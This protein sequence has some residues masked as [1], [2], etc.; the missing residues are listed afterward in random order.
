MPN[1]RCSHCISFGVSCTHVEVTKNLGSAKSY[2]E[3][4]EQRMAK[5]EKLFGKHLPGLDLNHEVDRTTLDEGES[6]DDELM[7]NDDD[8]AEARL[9]SKFQKLRLRPDEN[10]FY[11]KSSSV[12]LVKTTLDVK[13][14][15]NVKNNIHP[16]VWDFKR[17]EFWE[18]R[19]WHVR[20]PEPRRPLFKFPA[21][22]LMEQLVN[23]FFDRVNIFL[24][25]LHRPT[26][27]RY[28]DDG[29]HFRDREF[30]HVLLLVCAVASR[31]SE[32]P[33]VL[34]DGVDDAH[35]AGWKYMIQVKHVY[36][37]MTEKPSLFEVQAYSLS[38]LWN[39][40]SA[41]PQGTWTEIGLGIRKAMEVGAHRHDPGKVN[42][43]SEL[44]KRV[45]WV[46]FCQD[47]H[48]SSF[49]G[50]SSTL[51]S[52]MYD[53]ELPV[54][55]DDEYWD[56]GHAETCFKQPPGK[57]SKI[58]YFNQYVKLMEMYAATMRA[59]YY[60]K[61]LTFATARPTDQQ[62]ITMLDSAMNSWLNGLPVHL[63]WNPKE[64]NQTFFDQ[65]AC[66][67]TYYYNLQIFVHKPFIT[68]LHSD[69][70][71]TFPSLAICTSA[72]RSMA[73]VMDA[74]SQRG[75]IPLPQFH[76]AVSVA[77]FVLILNI[78]TGK[79]SGLM[80][81]PRDMEDVYKCMRMLKTCET[82]WNSAG[83]QYDILQDLA[84]AAAVDI[85]TKEAYEN[86]RKR[87]R[88]DAATSSLQGASPSTSSSSS[89]A[90]T[91]QIPYILPGIAVAQTTP[92]NGQQGSPDA[93]GN[94]SA[95]ITAPSE[96]H[97]GVLDFIT[98][99]MNSQQYPADVQASLMNALPGL[100]ATPSPAFSGGASGASPSGS[101]SQGSA[102]LLGIDLLG[103]MSTSMMSSFSTD[104]LL[105]LDT[106]DLT[107][108]QSMSPSNDQG[109][110]LGGLADDNFQF[111]FSMPVGN[112]N[113]S[114]W[115]A[116]LGLG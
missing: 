3:S 110:G 23:V 29:T 116:P 66:L 60:T 33:R 41:L 2:V 96:G 1:N 57:P 37:S 111:S 113:M 92:G 44:W 4:L 112:V 39:E 69:S 109:A 107:N 53:Q 95:T 71:L 78:W 84:S 52:D 76:T 21:D 81:N 90:I 75:V 30:A 28:I 56:T 102:D 97:N 99:Y 89:E 7:R 42:A 12:M 106:T 98:G 38:V 77:G 48:I 15:Y 45:F 26:F 58:E 88:E 94:L 67:Y 59:V 65:S 11:G 85:P 74:Q 36:P 82:R 63:Q 51:T 40:G 61:K 10:R 35:S 93:A 32:D 104:P 34:V 91:P 49:Y 100:S 50:H 27:Q 31:W 43:Q 73:R 87:R 14:I 9:L 46:L 17:P 20:P 105:G 79:Q 83:R 64:K 101:Q 22:D 115:N 18:P 68:P 16:K 25:L 5:M 19:P 47:I 13:H 55:C 70:R 86:S 62:T 6:D 80:P 103:D 24:P 54:P 114:M 8:S 72:A 108:L